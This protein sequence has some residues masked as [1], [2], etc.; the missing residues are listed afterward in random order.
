MNKSG[1]HWHESVSKKGCMGKYNCLWGSFMSLNSQ[2]TFFTVTYIYVKNLKVV[3]K[4]DDN[5]FF[6]TVLRNKAEWAGVVNTG[7][8]INNTSFLSTQLLKTSSIVRIRKMNV[9][10]ILL[11]ALL[12]FRFLK[13]KN[14]K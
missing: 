4:T 6:A 7:H 14:Q 9:Y 10:Y 13:R 12:F 3:P 1:S 11:C 8:Q 2:N 5:L